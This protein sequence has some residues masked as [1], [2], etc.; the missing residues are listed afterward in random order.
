MKF[1]FQVEQDHF[2]TQIGLPARQHG[3]LT[4]AEARAW[5]QAWAD[6]T[7]FRARV[8]SLGDKKRLVALVDPSAVLA[9][10]EAYEEACRTLE[11][12]ED[13]G[14]EHDAWEWSR[15][16]DDRHAAWQAALEKV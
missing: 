12:L 8:W 13:A 5:A 4:E 1:K 6:E 10:Q 3:T 7:G 11:E 15:V 2:E 9:L 14:Q 16:V